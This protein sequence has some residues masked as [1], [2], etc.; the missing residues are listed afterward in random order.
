MVYSAISSYGVAQESIMVSSYRLEY[1]QS[2]VKAIYHIDSNSLYDVAGKN[3]SEVYFNDS[4]YCNSAGPSNSAGP[5]CSSKTGVGEPYFDLANS[6]VLNCTLLENYP[7]QT[8]AQLIKRDLEDISG[9]S[10]FLLN[11]ENNICLDNYM[12]INPSCPGNQAQTP[13]NQQS[14]QNSN[15]NLPLVPGKLAL[16]CALFELMKPFH[17]EGVRYFADIVR[18]V[19]PLPVLQPFPPN[20]GWQRVTDSYVADIGTGLVNNPIP[21]NSCED[22]Q[23]KYD[24]VVFSNNPKLSNSQINIL[25]VAIPFRVPYSDQVNEFYSETLRICI[26]NSQLGN[27]NLAS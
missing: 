23:N 9:A 22:V 4:D 17:S 13:T 27:N 8:V 10:Q 6:P 2:V 18:E 25:T 3:S 15:S 7:H 16:R 1:I 12:G 24:S 21:F 5:K 26:W 20:S 11:A 14:S 19:N